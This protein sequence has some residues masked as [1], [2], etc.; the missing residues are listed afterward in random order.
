MTIEIQPLPVDKRKT[1]PKEF[2]F[3]VT[4]SDH[5][6]T[7][8]FDENN[9]W[10]DAKISPYHSISLDPSAAVF[11]YSQEIFEGLKAYRNHNG[12]INLF[13]PEE[14]IKRF[15]RSAKRMVM[16]EVNEKLHLEAIKSLVLL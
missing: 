12:G 9:G 1:C 16:P 14:N 3:G 4:F 13:R 10:H 5:M 2:S 11:H 6:F 7:Q 8:D 15:N